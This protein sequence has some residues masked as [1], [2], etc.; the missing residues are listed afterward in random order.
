LANRQASKAVSRYPCSAGR[1]DDVQVCRHI[2]DQ[3]LDRSKR[4]IE[5]RF[6]HLLLRVHSTKRAESESVHYCSVEGHLCRDPTHQQS[7]GSQMVL[8]RLA[9]KRI[10]GKIRN[11]PNMEIT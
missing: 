5:L 1:N 11:T 3:A 2:V 6:L 4:G 9:L 10:S 8:N 7:H